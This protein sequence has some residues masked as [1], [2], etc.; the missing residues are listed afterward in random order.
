MEKITWRRQLEILRFINK[1]ETRFRTN[2][3]LFNNIWREKCRKTGKIG[4]VLPIHKTGDK[5]W[6]MTE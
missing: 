5:R 3:C 1:Q 6:R 2:H 4:T